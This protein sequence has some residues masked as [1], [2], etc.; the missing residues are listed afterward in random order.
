M[1][2]HRDLISPSVTFDILPPYAA[3]PPNPLHSPRSMPRDTTYLL[4]CQRGFNT[5][6]MSAF[7]KNIGRSEEEDWT[8]CEGRH[9]EQ[10]EPSTYKRREPADRQ[11]W[12]VEAETATASSLWTIPCYG[13]GD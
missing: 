13:R 12:D 5:N 10:L 1:Y 3:R 7:F 11:K 2:N 6:T 8:A 4:H 9:P